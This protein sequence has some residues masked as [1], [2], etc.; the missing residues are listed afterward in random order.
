M[1]K[2][3]ILKNLNLYKSFG[4]EYCEP[5]NYKIYLSSSAN[6][7]NNNDTLKNYIQHCN[8][9]ELSKYCNSKAIGFGDI[10]SEI[11][12]VGISSSFQVDKIL[13]LLT[14]LL[15]DILAIDSKDVYI[16]NLIKCTIGLQNNINK[17]N[18]DLCKE[19]FIKQVDIIRPKYII[20]L[21]DVSKYLL[22]DKNEI[23]YK[24]G[25]CYDYNGIN[26][27][28]MLDLEFVYKN[29]S[30]QE[31]LYKDFKKLKILMEKQ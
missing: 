31:E 11:Y 27:I 9:C 19:Y 22:R 10:N 7:P 1:V 5:V 26:L 8:L 6:L 14:T 2:K 28:P 13:K 29:P 21:G 4:M 15:N 18:I 25:N 24:Y 3:I 17:E 20:A 12:I 16:T 23:S 30:Y